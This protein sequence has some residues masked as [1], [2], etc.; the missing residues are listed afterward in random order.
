MCALSYNVVLAAPTDDNWDAQFGI[1][2]ANGDVARAIYYSSNLFVAGGFSNIAGLEASQIAR[3]DG[4]HW[5][6]LGDGLSSSSDSTIRGVAILNGILYAGGVFTQAGTNEVRNIAGWDGTNWF[7]LGNGV[8]G[9]VRQMV[10]FQGKLIVGGSF[11]SAG[12]VP[13]ANIAQWDGTNWSALGSGVT[14]PYSGPAVDSLAASESELYVAGRFRT[15]NGLAATN[16][17]KW[18]GSTWSSMGHGLRY[19]NGS[20]SAGNG[21]VRALVRSQGRLIAG[22][23]FSLAGNATVANVA[24]WDGTNWTALGTPGGAIWVL[25]ANGPD[26]FAGSYSDGPNQIARWNGSSWVGL[27][28]GIQGAVFGLAANGVDL[29]VGGRF[30][31]AGG[32][33]ATNMAL[34]HI[35]H[36]LSVSYAEETMTISWPAT[37]TNLVLEGKGSV[38]DTNWSMVLNPPVVIDGQCRVTQPMD[39][40]A[41]FFRLRRK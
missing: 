36:T 14:W 41:R 15:A 37:G 28:S 3:F 39:S 33:P 9:I 20:D 10:V 22:G 6:A 12:G 23:E 1:P 21:I 18:N 30:P 26:V 29:F 17:A 16:I 5:H 7:A 4:A 2:G 32:K 35:P 34:W 27:G 13:A 24:A 8:G 19:R 25:A 31:L 38:A 11:T 40:R